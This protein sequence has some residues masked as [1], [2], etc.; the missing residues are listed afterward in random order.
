MLRS[1]LCNSCYNHVA[2][3]Q[4]VSNAKDRN[5][6]GAGLATSLFLSNVATNQF[7]KKEDLETKKYLQDDTI[8]IKI[9]VDTFQLVNTNDQQRSIPV[10]YP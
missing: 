10:Q 2:V 4:T 9:Q 1:F 8:F 3:L 6:W 7:I 5:P